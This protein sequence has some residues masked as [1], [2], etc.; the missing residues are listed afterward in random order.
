M[1]LL[2]WK[3]RKGLLQPD[4]PGR[5]PWVTH[6]PGQDLKG[7]PQLHCLPGRWDPPDSVPEV[8]PMCHEQ[9]GLLKPDPPERA[10]WVIQ[11]P[12]R[13]PGGLPGLSHCLPGRGG[14][15]G[16]VPEVFLV[17]R[18]QGGLLKPDPPG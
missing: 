17:C 4:P 5:V 1:K 11:R 3:T 2:V 6:G 14:P 13:V 18:E 12:G 7:V 8:F 9:G 15:P 10:P 16:S